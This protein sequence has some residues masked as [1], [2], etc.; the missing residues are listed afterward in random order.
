MAVPN[1]LALRDV[2]SGM[3]VPNMPAL[4]DVYS[5]MAVPIRLQHGPV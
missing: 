2:Y 5:G 4:R 1:M 3:A